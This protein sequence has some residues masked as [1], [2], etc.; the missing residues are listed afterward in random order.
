MKKGVRIEEHLRRIDELS[1]QLAAIGE[2][3]KETHKVAVLLQSVQ[4]SYPTLVTA[5]LARGDDD[6]TLTFIKQA[7]RN[8]DERNLQVTS[9]NPQVTQQDGGDE[10]P[11]VL[12]VA[13][14][15]TML[16]IA[17]N[18]KTKEDR[19]IVPRKPTSKIQIQMNTEVPYLSGLKA[20]AKDADWIIDSGA[21]RHM[22]FQKNTIRDYKE[23]ETPE[24][25]AS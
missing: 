15:A 19:S 7:L 8:K 13:S 23:F 4:E 14:L 18:L 24:P 3:V 2:E 1:D 17:R 11:L 6:I 25:V 12:I 21:S 5:L 22:T 9:A 20:D 10:K 16:G